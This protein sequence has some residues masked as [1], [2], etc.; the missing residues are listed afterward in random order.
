MDS[1]KEIASDWQPV[2]YGHDSQHLLYVYFPFLQ[3]F[4]RSYN[5]FLGP[6]SAY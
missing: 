4:I 3:N 6:E 2:S 5:D 1:I